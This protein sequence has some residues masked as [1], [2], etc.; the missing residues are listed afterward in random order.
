MK[1]KTQIAVV[2]IA[3]LII[4]IIAVFGPG[5]IGSDIGFADDLVVDSYEV[6]WHEDGTLTERFVFDAG[7]SGEIPDAL[8]FLVGLS[9]FCRKFTEHPRYIP[10]RTH[11]DD[12]PRQYRRV[13]QDQKGRRLPL[14]LGQ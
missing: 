6:T 13:H 1:E 5:L 9:L 2:F 7:I 12:T 10:H 3:T 14:Q 8:P 4:G 11:R